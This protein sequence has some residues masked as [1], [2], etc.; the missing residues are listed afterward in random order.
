MT[1]SDGLEALNLLYKTV[2]DI[3][4]T[5]LIMPRVSGDQLCKIIRKDDKLKDIFI[6]VY[7]AITLEYKS[8]FQDIRAD[9]YIAKGTQV[10]L[11]EHVQHVLQQYKSGIRRV[12]K[13]L[14][15]KDLYPRSITKELLLARKHYQ[16][17]FNNV[18][19]A[20]VEMD[21]CGQIIKANET[22]A[23]IFQQEP[24]A[25]LTTS[26][27]DYLSGPGSERAIEWINQSDRFE[28]QRFTS[29]Y[30]NPLSIQNRKIMLNMVAVRKEKELLIIGLLQDISTQ[31]KTE[32]HLARIVGEFNA[33]LDAIDY[34]IHFL[35]AELNTRIFN[36]AYLDMFR[37]PEDFLNGR[38]NI[39]EIFEY[40]RH[41]NIYDTA[42]DTYDRWVDQLIDDL[43]QN[44]IAPKEI[45]LADNKILQF[46]AHVL[47]NN[48]KLL[49]FYDIS[50]LKRTEAELENALEKVRGLA[51][52]DPLT[53]LPNLRLA[54]ENLHSVTS[55]AKRKGG[56]TAILF[57]D[58]DGFKAVNDVHGH[59]MGDKLL[60]QVAGRLIGCLRQSDTV[61]RIGGDEFLVIQSE[62]TRRSAIQ[63]VAEKILLNLAEPFFLEDIE[64]FIGASIGIAIYPTH[65]ED[66]R[67]LLKKADDAM[68][69]SKRKGKNSYTF[70][71]D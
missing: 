34:G 62:I 24:D 65:G 61:A 45:K 20:V 64:I 29:S 49:T 11:K 12:Q 7:S 5:D 1:A 42:P 16:T 56:N 22:C 59:E 32:E 63:K 28:S 44:V 9:V 36:Q 38:P 70:A 3:L 27:Q 21:S 57:I 23:T 25:I 8:H 17:I 43:Q 19:E 41:R 54:R 31:K 14:G 46:Q 52:H 69:S 6:A 4:F 67:T 39:R 53:G 30:E 40:N 48:E 13:I 26:F 71:P 18:C 37:L 2:P 10:K 68:Y 33:V 35:D 58:L 47:P 51:N 66:S 50:S 60:K 15:E 55:L